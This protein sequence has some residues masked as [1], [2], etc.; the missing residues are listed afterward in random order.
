MIRGDTS[1]SRVER[2]LP[3]ADAHPVGSE[4]PEAEDPFAVRHNDHAD[5]A[6]P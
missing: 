6:P 1:G 4:V 5:I 2:D 3:L